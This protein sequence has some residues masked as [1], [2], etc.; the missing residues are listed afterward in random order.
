MDLTATPAATLVEA[1]QAAEQD[2]ARLPWM[3]ATTVAVQL[4]P[5]TVAEYRIERNGSIR[6]VS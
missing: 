6:R 3:A 4:T 1:A 5:R 2:F